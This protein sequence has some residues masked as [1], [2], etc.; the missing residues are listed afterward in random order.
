[1]VGVE[2]L[3]ELQGRSSHSDSAF[4]SIS[5]PG[6]WLL[7]TP[8]DPEPILCIAYPWRV[9]YQPPHITMEPGASASIPELICEAM[10][11]I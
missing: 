2:V 4:S 8:L 6:A 3:L 1:M 5:F 11:R 7:P 10:R 9:W